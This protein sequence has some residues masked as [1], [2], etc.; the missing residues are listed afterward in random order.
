MKLID[1]NKYTKDI[2]AVFRKIRR[3]FNIIYTYQNNNMLPPFEQLKYSPLT[4]IY[5]N[6][7]EGL[8]NAYEKSKFSESYILTFYN[9]MDNRV[10][11]K[12]DFSYDNLVDFFNKYNNNTLIPQKPK[13]H[14]ETQYNNKVIE[15]KF[16]NYIMELNLKNIV[17]V[18]G[19]VFKDVY[20]LIYY[21][22]S[23]DYEKIKPIW[24]EL[25]KN[26]YSKRNNIVLASYNVL[27][28]EV[29]NTNFKNRNDYPEI[30][31]YKS[32]INDIE[33]NKKKIMMYRR[34][35]GFSYESLASWISYSSSFNIIIPFNINNLNS[36]IEN[37]GYPGNNAEYIFDKDKYLNYM[38]NE[39][40][41]PKL[42][43]E[44]LQEM[45]ITSTYYSYQ[46]KTA[47]LHSK[48]TYTSYKGPPP[49]PDPI[50]KAP[51]NLFFKTLIFDNEAV[52]SIGIKIPYAEYPPK[53]VGAKEIKERIVRDDIK[54][55][56]K[57][58]E[59]KK[60]AMNAKQSALNS[61]NN[62]NSGETLDPMNVN[63]KQAELNKI[64]DAKNV[65]LN[66][67]IKNSKGSDIK[68]VK[69]NE[70]N[71]AK[72]IKL[73]NALKNPKDSSAKQI[74]LNEANNAKNIKLNKKLT[75][76][77]SKQ[78]LPFSKDSKKIALNK[79]LGNSKELNKRNIEF[80]NI[81]L[82]NRS[83]NNVNYSISSTT[84][85]LPNN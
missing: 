73:N 58:E 14:F 37:Q 68:I 21:P 20:V 52:L 22:W 50:P 70:V 36:R 80:V 41:A 1:K 79:A 56:K 27:D 47:K 3:Q 59:A 60:L 77:K 39:H 61:V 18:T 53:Y 45:R 9:Y 10:E 4:I 63:S 30:V 85:H 81:D 72:Y 34:E 16:Q 7:K 19:D 29:L 42:N 23:E 46:S 44:D 32:Q 38:N 76:S 6:K 26:L 49:I 83:N 28:N 54:R 24:N 62:K 84:I 66:E 51:E 43:N 12:S 25:A 17:D 82:S 74:K 15:F 8:E 69:L 75:N 33:N 13:M 65:R 31:L 35:A 5:N 71:G 64:N 2:Y 78:S 11:E 48:P 67:A 55:E 40:L 57:K